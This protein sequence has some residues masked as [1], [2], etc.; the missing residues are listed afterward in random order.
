MTT[1]RDAQWPVGKVPNGNYADADVTTANDA[2]VEAIAVACRGIHAGQPVII[3]AT[4]NV[5]SG[6]NSDLLTTRIYQD[7]LGADTVGEDV[8]D[9]IVAGDH[10]I[11]F[12]MVFQ[13]AYQDNPVYVLGITTVNA[14]ANST[15][16]NSGIL[17][18]PVRL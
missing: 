11:T 13:A 14:T 4:A 10:D 5:I 9:D 1:E 17:V 6:A 7:A 8:D 16:S 12:I 3:M 15:I 2:E 18:I